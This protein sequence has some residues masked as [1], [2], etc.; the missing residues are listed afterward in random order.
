[1]MT[2]RIPLKAWGELVRSPEEWQDPQP[3]R[4]IRKIGQS[5]RRMAVLAERGWF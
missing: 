3:A 5:N 4:L 1:M 2:M